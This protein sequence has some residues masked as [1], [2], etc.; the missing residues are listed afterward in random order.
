MRRYRFSWETFGVVAFA[1]TIVLKALHYGF[2]TALFISISTALSLAFE[3]APSRLEVP[4]KLRYE[5]T[6]GP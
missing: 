4:R 5:K 2:A 1:G 3:E 6:K